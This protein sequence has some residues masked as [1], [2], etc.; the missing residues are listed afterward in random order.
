MS[1]LVASGLYVTPEE[2]LERERVNDTKSEY[3]AGYIQAMAGASREHNL[4]T[5]NI[6]GEL[7][8]QLRGRK[9]LPFGSD[10][11]LRIRH[12]NT[13]FYYYPDVTVDCSG[14]EV[15]EIE[16]PSV[17]F[18]VCSTATSRADHG[19]KLLNYLNLP[20]MRV[21]VL[22]EQ[23][24]IGLTVHRRTGEGAWAR[25]TLSDLASTLELPEIACALPL[26]EIYRLLPFAR[27]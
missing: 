6:F 2:Y 12:S 18:E 1:A 20:S 13:T 5:G 21:Y 7:R 9:C 22:V 16:E 15:Q 14:K 26:R 3:L 25:E 24:R 19:E 23:D 27:T 4:I 10:M 8:N 11:R 17:I